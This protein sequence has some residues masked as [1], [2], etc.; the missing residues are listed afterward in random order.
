MKLLLT[1]SNFIK[2]MRKFKRT[3]RILISIVDFGYLKLVISQNGT[4]SISFNSP[5][6]ADA[7][8]IKSYYSDLTI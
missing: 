7:I 6:F 3:S 1:L 5:I 2:F 4:V 8:L